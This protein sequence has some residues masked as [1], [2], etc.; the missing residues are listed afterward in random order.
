MR[1]RMSL[2]EDLTDPSGQNMMHALEVW[3]RFVASGSVASRKRLEIT[4]PM[5]LSKSSRGNPLQGLLNSHSWGVTGWTY[6]AF[7]GW[8]SDVFPVP[9]RRG[10][11][12]PLQKS[13]QDPGLG[14]QPGPKIWGFLRDS[15]IGIQS[16]L[17][18]KCGQTAELKRRG[19]Q[20]R[21]N[22][23]PVFKR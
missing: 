17:G 14:H 2:G 21:I 9:A 10:L 3:L 12:L 18:P 5:G 11:G 8:V 7:V 20:F 1:R 4:V 16:S 19:L 13:A 22:V 15:R 23:K 6:G